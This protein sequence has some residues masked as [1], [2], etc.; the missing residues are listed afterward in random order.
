M[1]HADGTFLFSL[2]SP[3]GRLTKLR[4]TSPYF[5]V[6]HSVKSGPLFGGCGDDLARP[7]STTTPIIHCHSAMLPCRGRESMGTRSMRQHWPDRNISRRKR[8]KC[9][10]AADRAEDT[11]MNGTGTRK[12]MH[13]PLHSPAHPRIILSLPFSLRHFLRFTFFLVSLLFPLFLSF[14]LCSSS[15]SFFAPPSHAPPLRSSPL[16]HKWHVKGAR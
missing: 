4:C 9:S 2:Q 1:T 3:T 13:H 12:S 15:T 7:R 14:F 5:A 16:G 11:E 8:W 10:S 6:F